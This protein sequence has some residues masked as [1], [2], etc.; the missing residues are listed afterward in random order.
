MQMISAETF[1]DSLSIV[2]PIDQVTAAELTQTGRPAGAEQ[3]SKKSATA[4]D[5]AIYGRRLL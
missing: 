1:A 2:R 5:S 3:S 4:M